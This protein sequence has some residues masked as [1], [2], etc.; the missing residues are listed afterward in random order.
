MTH[1]LL[2]IVR[3]AVAAATLLLWP[4]VSP[5]RE[6]TAVEARL[7][8]GN[9]LRRDSSP[10]EAKLGGTALEATTYRDAAGVPLFHAVP[11][12]G[13]GFVVTSADDGIQPVIAFSEGSNLVADAGNPLWT[14]L[15]RD[16]PQRR[17][18]LNA[19]RTAMGGMHLIAASAP[20]LQETEWGCLLD[21]RQ[22]RPLGLASV[23]DVRVSPVVQSHWGQGTVAGFWGSYNCYNYYSPNAYPCGCVATAMAQIMRKHCYPTSSL[24]AQTFTC[25]VNGTPT[26]LTMKGG[27]Y[28][29]SNMVLLPDEGGDVAPSA[30]IREAIGRLC[31]DAGVSVEMQYAAG[32]SGA[33]SWSVPYAFFDVFGYASAYSLG[34]GISEDEIRK[35]VLAN[36]DHGYPV[37]LGI[38]GDFG[39]AV[40]A[41]GYGYQSGARYIHLNMGW[42]GGGNGGYQ[43]AWYNVPLV[44]T[45]PYTFDALDDVVF[46][47]FPDTDRTLVSGSVL[48]MSGAPATNVTVFVRDLATGQMLWTLK[49]NAKGM[50]KF[51]W[52]GYSYWAESAGVFATDGA[53]AS[54]EIEVTAWSSSNGSV[55]NVWGADLTLSEPAS[56][57]VTLDA[58]GGA[59]G[60]ASAM[61]RVGQGL[62]YALAAPSR[63]G[64]A[65]L[66][67]F[68]TPED[69]YGTLYFDASMNPLGIWHDASV[70]TLYAHWQAVAV[71]VG[72][73]LVPYSWFDR[74]RLG[75]GYEYAAQRDQDG[76]G[77]L[78]WQ[79]YVTGSE[80]TNRNSVLRTQ[81]AV[82]NG[83]PGLAW[84]P[85]LGTARVYRVDGKTNL[86]DAVW[87]PTNA[88][89]RFFRIRVDMP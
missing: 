18:A 80:P 69:Y 57:V 23:S 25:R 62:P 54:G 39:H 51:S 86:T 36:L 11:L 82:S 65:L 46:N 43:N 24:P 72:D 21:E 47:I 52:E 29:W 34:W 13:G 14:L 59:G 12:K 2:L 31:Y 85:N 60:S 48:S 66:G 61:V 73:V 63:P 81:I 75:G 84:S 5:A 87:G 15:N 53:R 38:T 71:M 4:G 7:A 64:F 58:N 19:F 44:N 8:V 10:L 37:Y 56:Y 88:A 77:H 50:Y 1:R 33:Y 6:I 40:V 78:T 68:D 3:I 32:G 76:D 83:R 9:W 35:A 26:A 79:E 89:T 45:A 20:G 49:T 55:G 27:V 41:D 28:S 42:N 30:T 74:Y 22:A 67:Y 17:D 70:K 16:M